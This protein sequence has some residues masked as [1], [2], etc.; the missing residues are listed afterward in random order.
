MF[1]PQCL[2]LF[3]FYKSQIRQKADQQLPEVDYVGDLLQKGHEGIYLYGGGYT[4][5]CIC[6]NWKHYCV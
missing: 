5:V 4:G 3:H 1:G 2:K 6:Q